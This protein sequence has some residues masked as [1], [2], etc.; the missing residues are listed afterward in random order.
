MPAFFYGQKP[1]KTKSIRCFSLFLGY[2]H[3]YMK[4]AAYLFDLIDFYELVC[5]CPDASAIVTFVQVSGDSR[6]RI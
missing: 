1:T 4:K 5:T 6:V 3:I 2:V